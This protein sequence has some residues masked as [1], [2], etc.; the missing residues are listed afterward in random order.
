[1]KKLDL[2]EIILSVAVISIS[3]YGA[4]S[5]AQNFANQWFTRDDAYY[6]F[7]VAQNISEGHGSTFDGINPTNGYH[8]LWML[9]CIPIFSL[10]RFDLILP[11]RILLMVMSGLSLASGILLYRLIGRLFAPPIGAVIAVY[12]VFN[13]QI[14]GA[15]YQNGLETG[16]AALFI[17]LLIYRLSELERSWRTQDISH[18]QL[19]ALGILA[20]LTM[21]SRLDLIF[22]VTML[23]LWIIFRKHLLRHFIPLDLLAVVTSVLL[24]FMLVLGSPRQYYFYTSSALT[25]SFLALI[26]KIPLA[27]F[28]GLYER[29]F[30]NQGLW[31]VLRKIALFTGLGSFSV[32]AIMLILAQ[33]N[34]FVGFPRTALIYDLLFT[35]AFFTFSRL[36]F[37]GLHTNPKQAEQPSTPIETLRN[38][39]QTWLGEGLR[40]YGVIF[41]ALGIYMVWNKFAFGTFSPVS[42]QI[43]RWWATLPGN[44]YGGAAS[45]PLEF[46]GLAYDGPANTWAPVSTKLGMWSEKLQPHTMIFDVRYYIL[47]LVI[48]AVLFYALLWLTSKKSKQ[49]L[50]QLSV[51]PLLSG[52]LFQTYYYHAIGFSAFKG[53]YWVTQVVLVALVFGVILGLLYNLLFKIKQRT[54]IAWVAAV[55]FALYMGFSY[56][57]IM[58]YVMPHGQW[59]PNAPYLDI[60]PFLETSTEPGSLIGIT[61]GGTAG[62]F[63]H[64]RT[65]INIDG[66]INS[67]PYFQALQKQ[68]AAEYL[69]AEGLN[70]ILARPLILNVQPYVKQFN[71]YLERTIY[72]YEA[73]DLL[74][75]H[76]TPYSP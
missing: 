60:I 52:A 57:E 15:L 39:W 37:A 20:T 21:F 46:F 9:V 63:I 22:I 68:K 5:D 61:G 8:P 27:Y 32:G 69:A 53:W 35:F 6:Y 36:G 71:P 4:L 56:F 31:S 25:T 74:R 50:V 42:G 75:F 40:Y 18:K 70:Y 33:A 1:M 13:Y 28:I 14:T 19:I 30:A 2:F 58:R 11:L 45:T 24:A 48:F 44:T 17:L 54:A 29:S 67:Y 43:K 41:G 62:Y 3:L 34:F 66:L 64:D 12:W 38:N 23:G 7:K 65:I 16:L 26:I 59:S 55:V 73:K 51:M 76:P 47:L 49:A 10:A 72:S